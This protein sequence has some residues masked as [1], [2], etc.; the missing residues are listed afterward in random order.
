MRQ[1]APPRSA[2]PPTMAEK[3]RAFRQK[4][5]PDHPPLVGVYW[6]EGDARC[7]A[8][9]LVTD[10]LRQMAQEAVDEFWTDAAED[11]PQKASA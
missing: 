8:A 9:G 2:K 5:A 3:Q 6:R 4:H 7:L 10:S 11:A 1:A